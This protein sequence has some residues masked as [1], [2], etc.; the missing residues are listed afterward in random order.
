MS[1][2]SYNVDGE[3]ESKVGEGEQEGD[4][5]DSED[6]EGDDEDAHDEEDEG[7]DSDDNYSDLASSSDEDEGSNKKET[8]SKSVKTKAISDALE[9]KADIP[10]VFKGNVFRGTAQPSD[11]SVNLFVSLP[12]IYLYLV[13]EEYDEFNELLQ[14]YSDT[15]QRIVLERMIKSNHPSLTSDNKGKM[16]KVFAFLMQYI[17]DVASGES[18]KLLN[19]IVPVVFD[20]SQ[21]IPSSSVA[22]T[23]LDVLQEKR[24]EL[25]SR[26][27]KSVSL[28]TVYPFV[29]YQIISI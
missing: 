25:S 13:P 9:K 2:L 15:N 27:K 26:K 1:T 7:E 5:D 6:D 28:A 14:S 11:S 19:H 29:S 23:L 12:N 21:L 20:L 10:F 24:E 17:H 22:S 16:E 4:D 8:K 18:L 3:E